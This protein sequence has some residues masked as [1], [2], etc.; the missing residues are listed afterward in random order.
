MKK[1]LLFLFLSCNLPAQDIQVFDGASSIT[2][3]PSGAYFKPQSMHFSNLSLGRYNLI[4]NT[5]GNNIALGQY[6]HNVGPGTASLNIAIGNM[7][8]YGNFGTRNVSIGHSALQ[9]YTAASRNT[10]V[11]HGVYS[12]SLGNNNVILGYEAGKGNPTDYPDSSNVFIGYLAGQGSSGSNQLVIHNT[13]ETNP[14]I[15]GDFY[16]RILKFD[17]SVGI[18][19]MQPTARLFLQDGGFRMYNSI[20]NKS[21]EWNYDATGNYLYLDE[22]GIRRKLYLSNGDAVRLGVGIVPLVNL[23][24]HA[25]Q[26]GTPSVLKLSNA[27]TGSTL[28][29]G[30]M[31][32][33][34][35]GGEASLINQENA[36]LL[37]GAGNISG[38]LTIHQNQTVGIGMHGFTPQAKLHLSNV[39]AG[40]NTT[41]RFTNS[42]SDYYTADGFEL[43]FQS[44][45]KM[46]FNNLEGN[47]IY[48]NSSVS[49][50]SSEFSIK[51]NGRVGLGTDTPAT[52]L[53]VNGFTKLGSDAP[54]IKTKKLT[55]IT[56]DTEGFATTVAHGLNA[57]K[58]LSIT[59]M[60]EFQ[61]NQ[62]IHE[63]YTQTAERLFNWYA[64]TTNIS[65]MNSP[66]NSDL[67]RSKPF[68]ILITYE[69]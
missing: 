33:A 54:A 63:G 41:L 30:L 18:G 50:A 64:D 5:G 24:I 49:N 9:S 3:E 27:S 51:A 53:E 2:L 52:K 59:V 56:A 62:Y 21:W 58:I 29:D 48:F 65:V 42:A 8:S 38:T 69:E 6:I 16:N 31:L 7:N 68:R 60:V 28:S 12:Y 55:G 4:N 37:L 10:L 11:G 22:F 66:T 19:S 57:A 14:L 67:I 17:G 15:S 44:D 32:T 46:V 45:K 36:P 39:E 13:N 40:A 47:D 35:H 25:P 34:H 1:T 61:T 26:T 23:H 43:S 20:D